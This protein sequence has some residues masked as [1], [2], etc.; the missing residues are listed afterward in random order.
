MAKKRRRDS[1][2]LEVPGAPN[3]MVTYGDMMSLLMCFFIML[4]SF[5]TLEEK[6]AKEALGS[7]KAYLGVLKYSPD[8][9]PKTAPI[10]PPMPK[11]MVQRNVTAEITQDVRQKL[12]DLQKKLEK[13]GF[14]EQT[15]I[16]I[17]E[18]EIIISLSDDIL[19]EKG[20]VGLSDMAYKILTEIAVLIGD[21]PG[22]DIKVEGHTDDTPLT[23][24]LRQR[25]GSNWGLSSAR[26]MSVLQFFLEA[27]L[28][29]P[30]RFS[31]GG[32]AQYKPVLP[33][34]SDE[35]R[36]RN[37][38]VDIKLKPPLKFATDL[39]DVEYSTYMG[40]QEMIP[41][42]DLPVGTR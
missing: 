19:F 5:S 11:I 30:E 8:L 20:E 38:R 16:D 34:T 17:K 32:Y 26:A 25:Y 4:L 23:G 24:T 40:T 31:L 21:I 28:L 18:G 3:W 35:N 12:S 27:A 33:P 13:M 9:R 41:V 6:K 42:D 37:R 39:P 36:A 14:A 29:P 2:D 7:F 22:Y 10:Q 1:G 15:Q